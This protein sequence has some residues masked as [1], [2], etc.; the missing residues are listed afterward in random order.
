[1]WEINSFSQYLCFLYSV[2]MG[3]SIGVLYD[4]FKIDRMI[5]KRGILFIVFQ[6]ILFWI[7]SAFAFYSFSVVFSNG[8][9]RGYLLFGCLMGFVI[10]RLTLS[11][12]I[13]FLVIPLKRVSLA[14]RKFYLILL[15]KANLFLSFAFKKSKNFFRI[16][17]TK[18]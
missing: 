18:K 11:R 14:I 1:M 5:F 10:Y 3:S 17:A 8:Q 2:L 16:K 9:V 13:M 7:I 6:D 12:F 4:G 15:N